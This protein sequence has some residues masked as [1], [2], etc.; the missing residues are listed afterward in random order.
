MCIH[1]Y[2]YVYRYIYK[3]IYI[4]AC[5]CVYLIAL[6]TMV[7]SCDPSDLAGQCTRRR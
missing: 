5:V 6:A 3:A 4:Y 7:V 1:T 2:V